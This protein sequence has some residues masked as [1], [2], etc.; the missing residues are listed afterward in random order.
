MR[1]TGTSATNIQ[2]REKLLKSFLEILKEKPLSS[3]NV[4]EL[5]RSAGVSRMTFY[6]NYSSVEQILMDRLQEIIALYQAEDHFVTEE[7]KIVAVQYAMH[8]LQFMKANGHFIGCLLNSGMGDL[9]LHAITEYELHK[10]KC[11][12]EDMVL[13]C[14]IYLFAGGLYNLYV[15]WSSQDFAMDPESMA[16]VISGFCVG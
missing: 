10:W 13:N 4:V 1:R 7:D 15:L 16:N 11:T 6:R 5:T 8:Y 12:P 3:V 2:A 14:K 9:V